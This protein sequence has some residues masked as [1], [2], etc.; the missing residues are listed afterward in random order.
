MKG[1]KKRGYEGREGREERVRRRE[2]VRKGKKVG[3]GKNKRSCE[4]RGEG[5]EE[6]SL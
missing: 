3:K 4:G 6:E 5:L 2:A 1:K